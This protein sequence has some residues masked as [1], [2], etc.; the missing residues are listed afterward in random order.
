MKTYAKLKTCRNANCGKKFMPYNSIQVACSASCA[1]IIQKVHC[2]LKTIKEVKPARNKSVSV[3]K[4]E[5]QIVINEIVRIIDKDC[6]CISCGGN[7]L[8]QAGHY[9]SVGAK[10]YLRFN[11]HNIHVQDHR[12]N[13]ELTGNKEEFAKGLKDRHGIGYMVYVDEFIAARFRNVKLSTAELE[14][15]LKEAKSC[16]KELKNRITPIE[17]DSERLTLRKI[18]NNRIGIYK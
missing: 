13:I 3:L 16:L 17:S 2:E 9:H 15:A 11:L 8:P 12:C 6:G 14:H 10:P 4:S 7:K 5:L 1:R 18:Y